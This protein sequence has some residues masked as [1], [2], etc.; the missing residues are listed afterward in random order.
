[1]GSGKRCK[2]AITWAEAIEEVLGTRGNPPKGEGWL[3]SKE[4]SKKHKIGIVR[5]TKL[6]IKGVKEGIFEEHKGSIANKDNKIV[7]GIWYR[8]AQK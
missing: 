7:R 4:F 5:A 8:P 6:L 2:R 3:T 1:M